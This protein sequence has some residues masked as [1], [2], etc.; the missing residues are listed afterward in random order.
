MIDRIAG[1]FKLAKKSNFQQEAVYPLTI[2]DFKSFGPLETSN[3]ESRTVYK[4]RDSTARIF[5]SFFT[6]NIIQICALQCANQ[7]LENFQ[8]GSSSATAKQSSFLIKEC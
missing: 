2:F 1:A 7:N 6:P 3:F 5:L 4:E 8:H